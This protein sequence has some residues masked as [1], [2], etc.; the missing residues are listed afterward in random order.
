M[1]IGTILCKSIIAIEGIA[2]SK[3]IVAIATIVFIATIATI[4]SIANSYFYNDDS[5]SSYSY[6][7]YS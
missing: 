5:Y 3:S 4:V 2:I 1:A 6:S 7:Y